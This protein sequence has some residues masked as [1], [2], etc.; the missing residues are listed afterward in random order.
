MKNTTNISDVIKAFIE[1]IK[2]F[3]IL[4]FQIHKTLILVQM[5]MGLAK[6]FM[7]ALEKIMSDYR[8]SK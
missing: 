4:V 8:S 7:V 1:V 2:K 3:I 5:S 6:F